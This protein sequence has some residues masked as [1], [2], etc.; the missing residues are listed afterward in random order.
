MIAPAPPLG[1]CSHRPPLRDRRSRAQST[2]GWHEAV[3]PISSS[4]A[5]A[6]SSTA[7]AAQGV[8]RAT[9][10]E[11]RPCGRRGSL[12]RV[13]LRHAPWHKGISPTRGRNGGSSAL[14]RPRRRCDVRPRGYLAIRRA[15]SSRPRPSVRRT[16]R[17]PPTTGSQISTATAFPRWLWD[18]CQYE[19]PAKPPSSWTRSS[20]TSSAADSGTKPCSS[21]ITGSRPRPSRCARSSAKTTAATVKRSDGPTDRDVQ[22]RILDVLNRGQSVVNYYGHGTVALWT[23]AGLLRSS[24]PGAGAELIEQVDVAVLTRRTAGDG[25]EDGQPR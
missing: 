4:S 18:G 9:G 1:D 8:S 10:T 19:L 23:G 12:R 13:R 2:F 14:R 16:W 17:R 22:G 25:A 7:R 6:T 24:E 5:T 3:A 15:T 20:A 21:L 11:G